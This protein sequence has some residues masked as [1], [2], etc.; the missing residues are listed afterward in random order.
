M[1]IAVDWTWRA[2]DA[3]TGEEAEL[4]PGYSHPY[5]QLNQM[6]ADLEDELGTVCVETNQ[7]YEDEGRDAFA[8]LSGYPHWE[9]AAPSKTIQSSSSNG[10][11]VWKPD[12]GVTIPLLHLDANGNP[13]PI[14]VD[15]VEI[16]YFVVKRLQRAFRE[17]DQSHG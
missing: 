17:S 3:Q 7:E 11:Q 1:G 4:P 5:G 14:V 13:S 8:E 10:G 12:P 15:G 16:K 9:L 2:C 6:E